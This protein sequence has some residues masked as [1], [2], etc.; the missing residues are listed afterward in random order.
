MENVTFFPLVYPILPLFKIIIKYVGLRGSHKFNN[1]FKKCK[2]ERTQG[3]CK[4]V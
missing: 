3:E 1:N 2:N 4:Y